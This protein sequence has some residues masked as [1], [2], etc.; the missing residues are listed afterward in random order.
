M[1]AE[2]P[3]APLPRR[4]AAAG[5]EALLLGAV[6]IAVGFALAPVVSPPASSGISVALP[7][8]PARVALFASL[9]G[10]GAVYFGWFWTGGRRTLPMQTWKLGIVRADGAPVPRR[11]AMLRYAAFWIG[12]VLAFAAYAALESTGHAKQALWLLALNYAWALVDA[13]RQFLHDRIAGTRIV[14]PL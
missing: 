1:T 7:S 8:A 11:A 10:T 4:L 14:G 12:P 3:L 13:D 6:V 9:V 2:L 5:Y